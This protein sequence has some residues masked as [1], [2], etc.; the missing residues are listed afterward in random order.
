ML[1]KLSRADAKKAIYIDFEGPGRSP[2]NPA[3][4][5]SL[6]GIFH[7]DGYEA[8]I[9]D[10]SLSILSKGKVGFP[11]PRR[12]EPDLNRVLAELVAKAREQGVPILHFSRHEE[13]M[14]KAHCDPVVSQSFGMHACNAKLLIDWWARQRPVNRPSERTLDDYC[15]LGGIP[16]PVPPQPGVAETLRRLARDCSKV[17]RWTSLSPERKEQARELFHYNRGDCRALYKLTLKASSLLA[18]LPRR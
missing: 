10:P 11:G 17:R 18:A 14:I 3:P 12:M 5:P 13:E 2:E 9:L 8:V 4:R 6:L 16:C 7:Q 15:R 1:R